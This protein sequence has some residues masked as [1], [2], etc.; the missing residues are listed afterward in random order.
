MNKYT[1]EK[2]KANKNVG[3]LLGE[4]GDLVMQDTK[5]F[6]SSLPQPSLAR[7]A[8]KNPR[9]KR[10]EERLDQEKCTL[11]RR[12]SDLGALKAGIHKPVGPDEIHTQVLRN[13]QLLL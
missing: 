4:T 8:F 2:R 10:P 3:P 11:G 9:S 12:V 7:T 13:Q 5:Y 1:G 6:M